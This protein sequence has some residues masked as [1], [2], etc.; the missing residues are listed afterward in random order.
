MGAPIVLKSGRFGPYLELVPEEG[1]T[2][3]VTVPP[4]FDPASASEADIV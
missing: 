3:R 1:A 4:G 2:K